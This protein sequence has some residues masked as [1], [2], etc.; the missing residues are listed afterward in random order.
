M[1]RKVINYFNARKSTVNI[2]VIDLRKAFDKVNIYGLLGM[3]Q[4]KHIETRIINIFENWFG[5]KF[6]IIKWDG[7][8]SHRVPLLSGVKQGG[9]LSPLL[10]SLFVDI[11]LEKLEHAGIGCFIHSKCY[12]SF[13][14]ADDIILLSI[15]V[16]DL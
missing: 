12:N 2:G 16:T 10:F 14:Y 13:M 1:V 15:T 4:E 9:V 11:V 3:L 5:K 6:T 8:F 7:T